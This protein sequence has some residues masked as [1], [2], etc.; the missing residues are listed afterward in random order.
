MTQRLDVLV[1]NAG[2][3]PYFKRPAG[4]VEQTQEVTAP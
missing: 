2:I 3:N 1:A 4:P